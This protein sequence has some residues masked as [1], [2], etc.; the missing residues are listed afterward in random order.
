MTNNEIFE[1]ATELRDR[2]DELIRRLLLETHTGVMA[3]ALLGHHQ[4][5][6]RLC[7]LR[8]IVSE[9]DGLVEKAELAAHKEGYREGTLDTRNQ[10]EADRHEPVAPWETN[11]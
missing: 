7:E 1:R 8:Q 11:P 3:N 9:L 2:A 5:R 6:T 10:I 4:R